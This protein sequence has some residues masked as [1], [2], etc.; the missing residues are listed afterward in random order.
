MSVSLRH[1]RPLDTI[2]CEAASVSSVCGICRWCWQMLSWVLLN[3]AC[4]L[5][6]APAQQA[7]GWQN[8]WES[9]GRGAGKLDFHAWHENSPM[10]PGE[11][12]LTFELPVLKWLWGCKAL[13]P[14]KSLRAQA[15][16]LFLN[17]HL[18]DGNI[19]CFRLQRAFLCASL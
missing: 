1:P 3:A 2:G 5:L 10:S 19:S 6:A 14:W 15:L 7:W 12:V 18:Q 9:R 16:W 4:S 11:S 8:G 17:F 13:S